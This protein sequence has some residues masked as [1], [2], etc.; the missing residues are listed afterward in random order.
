[1]P[2]ILRLGLCQTAC[3]VQP[4][5]GPREVQARAMAARL[6]QVEA[7]VRVG[8]QLLCFPELS[9]LPFFPGG[10]D[11]RWRECALPA[12]AL[13]PVA[14]AAGLHRCVLVYPFLELG[15]GERVYSSVAVFDADGRALGVTRRQHIAPGEEA[16]L[17]PGTGSFPVFTTAA[18]LLGVVPGLDRNLP[19][20]A[21]ILGLRGAELILF[22]AAAT[23]DLP[24]AVWEAE[25]IAV[26]AQNL[27]WVAA[28]NRV[29]VERL[30]GPDG[31]T[32]REFSGGSFVAD[33]RGR[34]HAH[35][36]RD[37]AALVRA[38]V[39]LGRL[40]QERAQHPPQALRRPGLY[41]FLVE[42]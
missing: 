30:E 33:P 36:S 29:G 34:F 13:A 8:V 18:G 21:R 4:G 41:H 28:C 5:E 26:A 3:P 16:D 32:H 6:E 14:R 22:L 40:R 10:P 38:D 35:A 1:M 37:Q 42:P 27:L 25:P 24:R 17:D 2:S 19:E 39:P 20:V 31:A 7:A 9:A 11:R 23:A 12:E 15:H